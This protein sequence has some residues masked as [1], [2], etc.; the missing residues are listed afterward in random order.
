ML[1]MRVDNMAV[2]TLARVDARPQPQ[3]RRA[4]RRRALL[5][6][7]QDYLIAG[8][9]LLLALP[10]FVL[11]AAAIKLES[12]GHVLFRQRRHGLNQRIF[13]VFKFR[14]M[15]VCEDGE[16]VTQAK[17]GDKRIT[18]VGFILRRTS[19][20]ELP[21]LINVL[22]GEMSIVGPRP[23]ALAHNAYYRGLIDSYDARHTVKPGITGW[24]QVH[25]LRG[26]TSS[27]D[28]MAERVRYDLDYIEKQSIWLDLKIIAMTPL[29]ALFR[30][31]Y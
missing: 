1:A 22:R 30:N 24:A 31:A 28:Q 15:T 6:A 11:I 27:L 23:H 14:T 10:A 9:G 20:D 12:R 25:G 5:K 26:E 13:E 3:Q 16:A 7:A 2:P 17:R 18:R 19:L 29:F 21:Q 4:A 8:I